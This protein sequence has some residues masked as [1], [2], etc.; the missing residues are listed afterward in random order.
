VDLRRVLGLQLSKLPIGKKRL[1][2]SAVGPNS[3]GVLVR[4]AHQSA[5]LLAIWQRGRAIAI[6]LIISFLV[7]DILTRTTIRGSTYDQ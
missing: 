4:D 2:R 3:R 6:G 5:D 7:I 1:C